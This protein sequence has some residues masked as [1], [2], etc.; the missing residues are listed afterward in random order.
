MNFI[1][2]KIITGNGRQSFFDE[3]VIEELVEA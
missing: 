1:G 2:R 3:G